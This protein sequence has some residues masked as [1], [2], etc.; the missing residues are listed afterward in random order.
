MAWTPSMVT[1]SSQ[2]RGSHQQRPPDRSRCQEPEGREEKQVADA[3]SVEHARIGSGARQESSGSDV[4]E[5]AAVQNSHGER[6]PQGHRRQCG[7][8]ERAAQQLREQNSDTCDDQE[9][10]QDARLSQTGR[11]VG[12][13]RPQCARF[14]SPRGVPPVRRVPDAPSPSI[15]R[16]RHRVVRDVSRS[17]HRSGEIAVTATACVALRVRGWATRR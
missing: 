11:Q 2:P 13:V 10:E 1:L 16:H 12:S 5:P 15:T 8:D 14:A 4:G 3:F 9:G 6:E 7:K 17:C